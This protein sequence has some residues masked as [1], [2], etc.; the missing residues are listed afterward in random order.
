MNKHV[1]IRNMPEETHRKL[2]IRAAKE[3]MSMSDYLRL[4]IE[5]LVSRP[6]V[7]EWLERVRSREPMTISVED[8][9]EAIRQ[10]REQNDQKFDRLIAKK[11]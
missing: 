9:V 6:T 11:P 3:G 8:A 10:E 2:K 5:K 4:E 1:Q 7:K